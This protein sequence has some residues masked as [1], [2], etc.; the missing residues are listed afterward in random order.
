MLSIYVFLIHSENL[1]LHLVKYITGG[2]KEGLTTLLKI[3]LVWL[4]PW[5]DISLH[6]EFFFPS[7]NAHILFSMININ[8]HAEGSIND[9]E[10]FFFN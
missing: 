6:S 3:Q 1:F 5:P 7:L 8:V 9:L 10:N 2:K 4:Q